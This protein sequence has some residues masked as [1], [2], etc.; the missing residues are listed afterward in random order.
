MT[1]PRPSDDTRAGGLL[2]AALLPDVPAAGAPLTGATR[3]RPDGASLWLR[4]IGAL[5]FWACAQVVFLIPQLHIPPA[6][7]VLLNGAIAAGFVWW[8]VARRAARADRRRL[9]TF[10]IRPVAP[11]AARWIVPA[12]AAM[13]AVVMAALVVLPRFIRIPPD[14]T[15]FLDAYLDQPLGPAA[16]FVMVAVIA[17]L[18]EEFVFR[19]WM[20]RS[21]ERRTAAWTAIALTAA[22]F[23]VVHG[24][25]FGLPLRIAFGVASGYLAWRTRSIW[26]SVVLHGAYNGSLVMLSGALPQIDEHT[27]DRWAHTDAVF[28]PALV[29]LALASLT[30]AWAVRGMGDAA[31]RVRARRALDA[32]RT[33]RHLPG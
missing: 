31:A 29:A 23:G 10:R 7:G 5:L 8:F 33:R 26:P 16:V 17:P 19:G 20:Q 3:R 32:G 6:V 27:L 11:E 25:L 1:A 28:F 4:R 12:A 2:D 14:K 9:A 15:T 21:L 30:L 18:L 24:D 13:V 22:T